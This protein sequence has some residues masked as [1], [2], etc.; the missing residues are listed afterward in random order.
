[1]AKNI[2]IV[3]L[4]ILAVF[5]LVY[6]AIDINDKHVNSD[7]STSDNVVSD[8]NESNLS[9]KSLGD[10]SNFDEST[11]IY[12]SDKQNIYF[13]DNVYYSVSDDIIKQVEYCEVVPRQLSILEY[14]QT[15]EDY[16]QSNSTLVCYGLDGKQKI[17]DLSVPWEKCEFG[18]LT[19]YWKTS[20]S[21]AY[22]VQLQPSSV[23]TVSKFLYYSDLQELISASTSD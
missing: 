17:Q 3:V 18:T 20:D 7:D 2:C 23:S 9:V 11:M 8:D 5:E 1:M 22:L 15:F 6:I 16:S 21:K 10:T 13:V 19:V 14:L 4:S 12:E